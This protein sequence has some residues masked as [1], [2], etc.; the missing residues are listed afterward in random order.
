MTWS[1]YPGIDEDVL[2]I[3]SEEY[4]VD[5]AHEIKEKSGEAVEIAEEFLQWWFRL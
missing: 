4:T 5:D 1:R 2:W 3:P